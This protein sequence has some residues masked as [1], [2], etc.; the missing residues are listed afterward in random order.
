MGLILSANSKLLF[1][2]LFNGQQLSEPYTNVLNITL[3][4]QEKKKFRGY[5]AR[6]PLLKDLN[7]LFKWV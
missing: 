5:L 4:H 1:L 7:F 2:L 6:Y 3:K